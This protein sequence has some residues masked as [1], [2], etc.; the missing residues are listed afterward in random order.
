MPSRRVSSQWSTGC[1]PLSRSVTCRSRSIS[2]ASRPARSMLVEPTSS[3]GSVVPI[4]RSASSETAT[5]AS[6]RSSPNRQVF[7]T[8]CW[9][10]NGAAVLGVVRPADA[11]LLDPRGDGVEVVV[12]QPEPASD[13]F[14]RHEIEHPARLGTPVG[15]VEQDAGDREQRVRLGERTVGEPDLQPVPRVP[16]RGLAGRRR[17]AAQPERRLD[18][19]GV[20]LDVGAH[21]EDVARLERGVVV[22]QAEQ[23]LAEH[24]DL[25]G[26]T[27]TRV[28]LHAAIGSDRG[29]DDPRRASCSP[30][31]RA[32]ASRAGSTPE[33]R[34]RERRFDDIDNGQQRALQ[35]ADVAPQRGEQRVSGSFV[36]DVVGA[37]DRPLQVGQ[38]L[39]QLVGRV[40]K[41]EVDVAMT[42]QT[43]E[44]L[45]LGGRDA[46][47]PEQREPCRQPARVGTGLERR[48]HLRVPLVRRR[49]GDRGGEMTPQLRLPQE[50]GRDRAAGA[51]GV[52]ALLPLREETGP[53]GGVGREQPGQP[54]RD[55]VATSAAQLALLT[56]DTTAEMVVERGAPGLA[57]VLVEHLE[58]RPDQH[59]GRP[60]VVVSRAGDLGDERVRCPELDARAHAVA[61]AS[62]AEMVGQT[63][64]QPTLDATCRDEHELAG[65][66]IGQRSLAG[67]RRERRRGGRPGRL[68]AGS[69]AC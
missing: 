9:S 50:I 4:Q 14:D 49:R 46:G 28:H 20:G 1:V 56:V 54:A 35:L 3:S 13:R 19:R 18:E 52:V 48:E 10:P 39:P 63:L 12:R 51:V 44:Q 16:G 5:P 24:L 67:A 25:T 17:D 58:Q 7:C 45:G 59:V 31:C 47:V 26:R 43:A 57:G 62:V 29:C 55:G 11:G 36:R 8:Y 34:W 22:E 60:R 53:L 32:A 30:R 40:R 65:E 37:D 15:E 61:V 68:G 66:R 69:A 21:D 38:Q 64:A 23:R 42:A 27:V 2:S 6:T 33:R 41:P